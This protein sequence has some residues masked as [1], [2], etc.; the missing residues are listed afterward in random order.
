MSKAFKEHNFMVV[1]LTDKVLV[2]TP[3]PKAHHAAL[4]SG[5]AGYPANP[6]WN[7]SKFRAWKSG[8]QLRTAL[9]RGEMVVRQVDSMLVPA[10]EQEEKPNQLETVPQNKRFR[11]PV[12]SKR[13][14]A[15]KQ[16]A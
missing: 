5:F 15:S 8:C 3:V 14:A 4:R 6:R 11:F 1:D 12:W 2:H 16:L 7:V 10:T 13:V 9:A